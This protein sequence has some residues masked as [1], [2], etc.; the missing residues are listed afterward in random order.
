MPLVNRTRRSPTARRSRRLTVEALEDRTVPDGEALDWTFGRTGRVEIDLTGDHDSARAVAIDAQGRIVAAGHGVVDG[1]QVTVIARFRP[2]GSLDPTFGP[3]GS[4][5]VFTRM[6]DPFSRFSAAR[7]LVIDSAGRLIVAGEG[8]PNGQAAQFAAARYL[9]DGTLDPTFGEDG[10][11]FVP[12]GTGGSAG[13]AVAIDSAG[14]VVMAGYALAA[15]GSADADVAVARLLPDG[16]PDADFGVGG[17]VVTRIG[18]YFDYARGLTIDGAGRILVAGAVGLAF[19]DGDFAVLRYTSAGELD[20]T[21]GADGIVSHPFGERSGHASEV[22]EDAAGRIV[23]V[24]TGWNGTDQDVALARFLADGTPDPT[25]GTNGTVLAPL[26]PGSDD[27]G[28][29]ALL[30]RTGRIVAVGATLPVGETSHFAVS[31]FNP[32][33]TFDSTFGGD[34]SVATSFGKYAGASAVA[35]DAQDRLTVAGFTQD[36]SAGDV[37]ASF[38]FALT[39]YAAYTVPHAITSSGDR[40]YVE[41]SAPLVVDPLIG[42]FD[43]EPNLIGATVAVE[44]FVPAQDEIGFTVR[45][46]IT[47]S[48]DPA[49]GLLT[50]AG[51]VSLADYQT[52]LR[53]VT[54]RNTSDAPDTRPRTFTFTLDDGN[55]D[56]GLGAGRKTVLVQAINDAPTLDGVPSFIRVV[57]GTTL[58]FTATA[59]DPDLEPGLPD[60]T[61]SLVNAPAGAAIDPVTGAFAWPVAPDA[62]PADHTFEVRVADDANP[63]AHASKSITVR[64]IRSLADTI[65]T[66]TIGPGDLTYVENDPPTAVAPNLLVSDDGPELIGASVSVENFHAGEDVIGYVLRTGI[67]ASFDSASGT[68]TLSGTALLADYQAVLR[69]VTYRNTSDRPDSSP[70]TFTFSLDDGEPDPGRGAGQKTVQVQPVND[71]PILAGVP[72]TANIVRGTTF[73][74]TATAN[75]ADLVADLPDLTFS[76]VNAPAGAAIDPVTGVFSWT[77]GTNV[78]AGDYTFNVVVTDDASPAASATQLVTARVMPVALVDGD[79]VVG[80]TDR[81]DLIRLAPTANPLKFTVTVNGVRTGPYSVEDLLHGRVVVHG[82]GGADWIR[83]VGDI[84]IPTELDGGAGNDTVFGGRGF[85]SLA[86]GA[87]ADWLVGGRLNDTLDGGPGNDTLAG[88]LGDDRYVFD[89]Q[90]GKD[91]V[92]EGSFGGSD[93]LDFETVAAGVTTTLQRRSVVALSGANRVTHIGQ[94]VNQV[95]GGSG[96]DTLIGPRQGAAW[97]LFRA[98]IGN[99]DGHFV[100]TRVEN[101]VGGAGPDEFRFAGGGQLTGVVDGGGGTNSLSY[102]GKAL[103]VEVNLQTQAATATGGFRRIGEFTGGPVSNTLVGTDTANTWWI[104]AENTGRVAGTMFRDFENLTG[105]SARDRFVLANRAGVSGQLDGAAGTNNLNYSAYTTSVSVNLR[106]GL[107]TGTRG[108]ANITNVVG[109]AGGDILVGSADANA[110]IG[111]IGRDIVIGGGGRDVLSGGGASDVLIGGETTHDLDPAAL[112]ALRTEWVSTHSYARRVDHL[113]GNLGGGLNGSTVL[114]PASIL[115]D[116]AADS[117]TG[118]SGADWFVRHTGDAAT[119]PAAGEIVTTL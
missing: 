23:A 119:D 9:P 105:G 12:M 79:L 3:A 73:T 2:D 38:N 44:N 106:L 87:G 92:V 63:A 86:G 101:L 41:N 84:R 115:D 102:A 16:T 33:G 117:L 14:R 93:T 90:W 25:F 30:D 27:G 85:D 118:G 57:R 31:R 70:R 66:V 97:E 15:I 59:T 62:P 20:P 7:G 28:Y 19:P 17:S 22:M 112:A 49:L 109:G 91:R 111:K 99:I 46:G 32:D 36:L 77:V 110:L 76:L 81:A 89:N 83:V 98:D 80:G 71:A 114:D 108:V 21:F 88:G 64:V 82:F 40:S 11:V 74:F 48:F 78:P 35:L 60:L 34:G 37:Y 6:G 50:L 54:Y 75:D 107:A 55:P 4:G 116:G 95:S 96:M 69:S 45:A 67:S 65:P 24:G 18:D 26:S 113:I 13:W 58:E 56:A 104:T 43:D 1:A 47:G 10:T 52:V 8:G 94:G 72:A 51:Q 103:P 100:Y 39:R 29:G 61:F 42:V 5:R 68:L 53:S